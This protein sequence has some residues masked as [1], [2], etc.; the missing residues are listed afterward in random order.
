M[1]TVSLLGASTQTV[2]LSFLEQSID[3]MIGTDTA[4]DIQ[5]A[6]EALLTVRAI[7]LSRFSEVLVKR[8]EVAPV[9]AMEAR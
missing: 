4:A 8:N 5:T 1:Q 6:L 2:A 9:R 7:V 3:V